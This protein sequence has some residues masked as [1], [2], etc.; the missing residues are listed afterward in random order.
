[1]D[2]IQTIVR[3]SSIITSSLEINNVLSNA[4][5][6][7][8]E[9]ME[10][11]AC[12]IF[13]LDKQGNE[14][15]FC[16]ARYDPHGNTKA[17]KMKIGQGVVGCAADTGEVIVVPDTEKDA[18]FNSMV[19]SITG[20][21]TKSIIAVPIKNKER[22]LG[23]IQVLNCKD[24]AS[25]DEKK[26]EVLFIV[27]GQIGIA[28]ENA[29]LYGRLKEKFVLTRAELKETQVKLLRSERLAAMGQLA[30][31]IAHE[32][33]NPVMSI[34]GLAGRL[35]KMLS[36]DDRAEQYIDIIVQEAARL[37]K[38]VVDVELYTSLPEPSLHPLRLSELIQ[39]AVHAWSARPDNT[40]FK[41][42]LKPMSS[43]PAIYVDKKLMQ[44]ALIR[45]L[46]NARESM[47][48]KGV[49]TIT[50]RRQ[51]TSVFIS[52]RDQGIGIARKDLPRVFDPFF[53]SK[54]QGAGLG[55]SF[56]N[57]IVTAH[58]GEVKINSTPGV[59]TEVTLCFPATVDGMIQV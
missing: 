56:V 41:V 36:S 53:T 13:E 9:L 50:T 4:M 59:G 31:G 45:V 6:L 51:G 24:I 52:L 30:H 34:G 26:M 49:I 17:I 40:A 1:M 47:T 22:I 20:F 35:K 38:M 12:S 18:R 37:E 29:R 11:E 58:G 3:I 19:D 39:D 48:E 5:L 43:D 28:M 57:Q 46:S 32:V 10:A 23:V 54:M 2:E 21:R 42:K 44:E 33:R 27:A 7:V 14:L 55:L 8:E 16:L 25:F 15:S